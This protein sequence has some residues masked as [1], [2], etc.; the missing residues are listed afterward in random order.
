LLDDRDRREALAAAGR[1]LFEDRF[2][3][4]R[5]CRRMVQLYR[6]IAHSTPSVAAL[7]TV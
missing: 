6:Q 3:L 7:E 4:E 1:R 2:M 5:S